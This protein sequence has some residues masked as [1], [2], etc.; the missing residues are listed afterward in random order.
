MI[1]IIK[2]ADLTPARKVILMHVALGACGRGQEGSGRRLYCAV[3]KK[4]EKEWTILKKKM[5]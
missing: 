5:K 3:R 2:R 4:K 1:A